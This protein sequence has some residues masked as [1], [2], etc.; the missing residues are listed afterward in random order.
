MWLLNDYNSVVFPIFFSY[1]DAKIQKRSKSAIAS[2]DVLISLK[3]L[4]IFK[5][6]LKVRILFYL[7]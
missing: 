4:K 2:S 5:S 7:K 1:L 6:Y 3:P